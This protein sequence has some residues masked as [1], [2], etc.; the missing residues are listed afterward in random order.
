[1]AKLKWSDLDKP[2]SS[3]VMEVIDSFGFEKMTPVQVGFCAARIS[4]VQIIVRFVLFSYSR[5]R[6][7]C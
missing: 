5:P 7:R 6:F 4:Q 1:M 2:L 3:H